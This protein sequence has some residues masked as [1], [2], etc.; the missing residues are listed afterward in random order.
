MGKRLDKAKSIGYLV[1]LGLADNGPSIAQGFVTFEQEVSKSASQSEALKKACY[2]AAGAPH[3]VLSY[4]KKEAENRRML[5]EERR[6]IKI[7]IPPP[8]P[9]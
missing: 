4:A 1:G 7:V 6:R 2:D 9:D 8:D 3:P 5:E